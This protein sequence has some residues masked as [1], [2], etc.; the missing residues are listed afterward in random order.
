MY[1]RFVTQ[2][3]VKPGRLRFIVADNELPAEY[4]RDFAEVKFSYESPT[5]STISHP[6]PAQVMTLVD[7]TEN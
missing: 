2:V 4:D 3:G 5:I 7:E 1:R 6:G